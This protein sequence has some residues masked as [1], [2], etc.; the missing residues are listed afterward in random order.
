MNSLAN[1][2]CSTKYQNT[3][4]LS[5]AQINDW[6][7]ELNDWQVNDWQVNADNVK[8]IQQLTRIFTFKGYMAGVEFT[9]LVADMAEQQNHHPEILLSYGKVKVTWWTHAV[10]GLHHNDFICAAKCE[11]LYNSL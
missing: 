8:A 11:V 3:T 4:P 9:K 6:L 10:G 2:T 1:S 5:D 7:A